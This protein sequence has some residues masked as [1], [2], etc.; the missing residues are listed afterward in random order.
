MLYTT[1]LTIPANTTR[2]SPATAT[3]TLAPGVV[4]RVMVGFPFGCANLAHV[5]IFERE[6][7]V[8]PGDPD[9]DFSW[10]DFIFAWDE[11]H[12]LEGPPYELEI[13]GWNED[14]TYPHTI[15]LAMALTDITKAREARGI[16]AFWNRFKQT[17]GI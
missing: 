10:D 8:W 9:E 14:D 12:E 5:A 6:H 11:D 1:Q 4:N 15:L 3:L 2:A 16:L 13:R 17:V 7:Q